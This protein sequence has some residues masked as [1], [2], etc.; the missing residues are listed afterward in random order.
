[1]INQIHPNKIKQVLFLAFI[2]LLGFMI[3]RE[4]QMFLSAFLGAVSLYVVSRTWMMK[5]LTQ[6][7]WKR[8]V[9]ALTIIL[10]CII[11]LMIPFYWMS[12]VIV[13]KLAPIL[14][15][16]AELQGYVQK[17]NLFLQQYVN[18]DLQ[19]MDFMSQVGSVAGGVLKRLLE[20]SV[21]TVSTFIFMF[22]FLYFLLYDC[23]EVELWFRRALPFSQK[24]S[25]TVINELKNM[26]YSNAVGIPLVAVIQGFVAMIGYWIFG[27]NE[28]GLMG[29]LTG[30]ASVIPLLGTMVIFVPLSLYM[31]ANGQFYQG[32]GVG[33]WG[34]I[35]VG[36]FDN[37]VRS[38]V[39]KKMS[40][41]HPLITLIGAL[42]GLNIFG[43]FGVI[44][45][46]IMLSLFLL[47]VKIYGDEFGAKN[48]PEPELEPKTNP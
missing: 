30:I 24:N 17:I 1:M 33:L 9:A 34:I 22:V 19:S 38:L 23:M 25:N 37:V 5:L 40:N 44:F 8:W 6:L 36:T 21:S 39:Q 15:N 41:V 2:L 14:E 7:K 47:L 46:P 35:V 11:L 48:E 45:G 20:S 12:T 4:T 43:F 18:L 3:L 26:I 27:V 42:A 16:T 31:M 32:I 10:G 28:F 29:I 13:T